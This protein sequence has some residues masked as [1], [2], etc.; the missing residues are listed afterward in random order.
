MDRCARCEL[1]GEEQRKL[2]H[3]IPFG[4]DRYIFLLYL[5]KLLFMKKILTT[6]WT[7]YLIPFSLFKSAVEWIDRDF[8]D[9][10]NLDTNN[11]FDQL[12]WGLASWVTTY[13]VFS[14][15]YAPFLFWKG[16]TFDFTFADI[17]A[18]Y[19]GLMWVLILMYG[20]PE[21]FRWFK[22]LII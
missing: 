19:G 10:Y 21:L 16:I 4:K 3:G 17:T 6:L 11:W 13:S 9:S 22:K 20:I 8:Y 12:V 15:I 5:L 18:L 14:A 7:V 1:F 2:S